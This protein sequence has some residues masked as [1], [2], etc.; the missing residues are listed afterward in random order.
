MIV[1]TVFMIEPNEEIV[2]INKNTSV[3]MKL[4]GKSEPSKHLVNYLDHTSNIE[5]VQKYDKNLCI[6]KSK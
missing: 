2:Y 3:N 1:L 5:N 6:C 4:D